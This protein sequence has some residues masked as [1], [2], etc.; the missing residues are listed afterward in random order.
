MGLSRL[1][2]NDGTGKLTWKQG[3]FGWLEHDNEHV[4]FADLDRD[5][6]VD[7][8]FAAEEDQRN[9]I[10]LGDGKA[11]FRDVATGCLTRARA[12]AWRSATSTA[13]ACPISSSAIPTSRR[14]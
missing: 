14:A 1:Y 10:F 9:Q 2:L 4:R 12:T 11:G 3:V 5:G 6:H 13:M 8:V 7:V